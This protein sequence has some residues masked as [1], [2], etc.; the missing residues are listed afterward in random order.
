MPWK[1]D[2]N[3][4]TI[5]YGMP[6]ASS[7]TEH[8]HDRLASRSIESVDAVQLRFDRRPHGLII[9]FGV[10][11]PHAIR[12]EAAGPLEESSPLEELVLR[13]HGPGSGHPSL[14]SNAGTSEFSAKGQHRESRM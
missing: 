11:M 10:A 13:V 7:A 3:E 6:A 14:P 5:M 8:C 2:A 4:P 9:E 12:H 1:S